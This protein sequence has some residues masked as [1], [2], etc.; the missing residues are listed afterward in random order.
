MRKFIVAAT[1]ASLALPLVPAMAQ[2]GP[3]TT[4]AQEDR[5][6]ARRDNK[7]DREDA[8]RDNKRDLR[9]ARTERQRL[10][11]VDRREYR[12]FDYDRPDPRY[13]N[14][15]ADRYYYAS[16]KYR[17]RRL[18]ANDRIYRGQ[19]NRYYCRR[20]DGTTGLIIGGLVGGLLGNAIAPGDS[21]T[22]GTLFGAGAGAA[23]GSSIG[24]NRRV[25]C[26]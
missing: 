10:Q 25:N 16:S 11:R 3:P 15:Q 22:L 14:Y 26:R 6:D 7:R 1:L 18:H 23:I 9:D 13:G 12:R 5:Q 20:S 24:R 4:T 8:R 19:D 17:S 21:R 2:S